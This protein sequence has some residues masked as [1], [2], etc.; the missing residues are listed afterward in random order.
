MEIALVGY[1]SRHMEDVCRLEVL[2]GPSGKRTWSEAFKG[3]IV[4][5]TLV[6]GVTVNEVARRHGLR[7][8]HLSAWRRLA[9]DGKL[10]IPDFAGAEFIPVVVAPAIASA[11]PPTADCGTLDVIFG[12]VTVRMDASTSSGRLS[13]IIRALNAQP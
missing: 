13:E 9:K 11:P 2:V 10:V 5:E 4:A 8:N 3:R 12:E 1:A 7:P 6:S